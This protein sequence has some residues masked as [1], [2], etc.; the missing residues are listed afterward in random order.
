M[1]SISEINKIIIRQLGRNNLK[2]ASYFDSDQNADVVYCE[3]CENLLQFLDDKCIF[4]DCSDSEL[5]Q[6]FNAVITHY[7]LDWDISCEVCKMLPR[8][9]YLVK[10]KLEK[11]IF[12][13]TFDYCD[14]L[15]LAY[16]GGA[17]QYEDYIIDFLDKI[18]EDFR[19][20]IF[21][22]CYKLN[23]ST[24]SCKLVKKFTQWITDPDFGNGTGEEYYL[25]KFVEL[26]QHKQSPMHCRDFIDFYQNNWQKR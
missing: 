10:E 2:Y 7:P 4:S 23:T 13:P 11:I 3:E 26:W 15:L 17:L 19:D 1:K 12:N 22:A 20:G 16:L 14:Q 6:L 18:P 24:I 25:D 5:I 8:K 9:G 21:L